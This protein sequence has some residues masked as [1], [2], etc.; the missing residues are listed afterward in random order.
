[1]TPAPV[2]LGLAGP[3]SALSRYYYFVNER[4][5]W[6]EAQ[7]YCR[8]NYT[9]LATVETMEEMVQLKAAIDPTYNGALWIGLQRR[10]P[11]RWGWSSGEVVQYINWTA[12]EPSGIDSDGLCT[13]KPAYKAF[14]D[15]YCTELLE[16]VCSMGELQY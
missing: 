4:K 13:A 14:A 9:D 5:T 12:G 10:S 16:F 2:S 15:A 8:A 7:A 1:M 6:P 11:R 3:S